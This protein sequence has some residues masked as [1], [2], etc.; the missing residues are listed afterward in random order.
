MRTP[1]EAR[2][3]A[4]AAAGGGLREH[5]IFGGMHTI[6]RGDVAPCEPPCRCARAAARKRSMN[7]CA[8]GARHQVAASSTVSPGDVTVTVG[9]GRGSGLK[10]NH[11]VSSPGNR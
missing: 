1:S 7:A 8:T 6:M 11:L 10:Q 5:L 9:V 2:R 3:G 4:A